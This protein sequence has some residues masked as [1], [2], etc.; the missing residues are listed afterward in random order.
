MK[1]TDGEVRAFHNI[2]RHRGNKLVWQDYPHEEIERKLP[3]VHLQVPRLA[4]RPRGRADLR[5]AG[6]RVLRPRLVRVTAWCGVQTEVWEGFIFVNLDRRT[7][8]RSRDYLGELG[9]GLEGYPFGEMTEVYKYRAEI[10]AN[11]KLFIDAFVEFYHAPVL[12]AKQATD[13]ESRKLQGYG[14]EALAYRHRGPPRHGLVVGRHGAAE[15]PE[16]WSSRSSGC[17]AAACSARGTAPRSTASTTCR[18]AVN[19][20]RHP[21]WGVDSLRVLPQ[22]H[23]ARLGARLVPHVPLLADVVQHATPSRA[24]ST[25]CRRRTPRERLAPGA[26]RGHVQ[27]VRAAGRQ[28][29]RGHAVDDRVPGG[30]QLP[31]QRP[32]DP[33]APPAT[34]PPGTWSPTT[35]RPETPVGI[36]AAS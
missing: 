6:V 33:P 2:C 31:A 12:H 36:S 20:A 8:R 32:G 11:W 28:H 30:D 7:P 34:R 15:G 1:G 16:T 3:P 22:L 17:C 29:P 4:L 10:G 5:A 13:E 18:R 21:A 14:F 27:G 23:A 35:R 25:S 24:P 26:R 9:A 19:P